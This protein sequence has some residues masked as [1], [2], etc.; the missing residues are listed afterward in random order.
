MEK[1]YAN[2]IYPNKLSDKAPDFILSSVS[3]HVTKLIEWLEA[4]KGL[5]NEKGYINLKGLESK[6][7][8]KKY[9]EVDTWK[10]TENAEK[11]EE[12]SE[13]IPF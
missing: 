12:D 10:P 9:F 4:N 13:E 11:Q 3:I 2:G 1:K 5:A 6:D 7:K 8:T